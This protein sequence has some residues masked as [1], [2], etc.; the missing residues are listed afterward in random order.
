M[1]DHETHKHPVHTI[2]CML[3]TRAVARTCVSPILTSAEA[4]DCRMAPLTACAGTTSS[5]RRPSSRTPASAAGI[6]LQD[7]VLSPSICIE[8][9]NEGASPTLHVPLCR[10]TVCSKLETEQDTVP[11]QLTDGCGVYISANLLML[12]ENRR[13]PIPVGVHRC[14]YTGGRFPGNQCMSA[15]PHIYLND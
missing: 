5:L 6:A 7:L 14:P 12:H 15:M 4:G 9:E 3:R 8:A 11:I 13:N 10:P 2:Q 1:I